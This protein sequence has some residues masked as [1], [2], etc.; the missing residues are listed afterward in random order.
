MKNSS[1]NLDNGTSTTE[2]RFAGQ[3]GYRGAGRRD[4]GGVPT[5]PAGGELAPR[6]GV[7]NVGSVMDVPLPT[8]PSMS[9]NELDELAEP[10]FPPSGWLDASPGPLAD[11]PLLRGLLLELPPRGVTPAPDLLDRWFEAARS[12]LELLYLRG[13]GLPVSRR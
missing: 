4:P 7:A 3:R 5:D 12:I 2:D 9:L 1:E 13:P 10:V 11:H 8:Q 6:N